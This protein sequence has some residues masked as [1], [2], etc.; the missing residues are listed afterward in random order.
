MPRLPWSFGVH[1]LSQ[2][3][4]QYFLLCWSDFRKIGSDKNLVS[5][6]PCRDLQKDHKDGQTTQH[7]IKQDQISAIE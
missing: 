4:E 1:K 7:Q 5:L 2:F 3:A 6:N